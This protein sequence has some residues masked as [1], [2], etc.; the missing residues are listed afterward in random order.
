VSPL[1]GCRTNSELCRV[2]RVGTRTCPP[3]ARRTAQALLAQRLRRLGVD[4]LVPLWRHAASKSEATRSAGNGPGLLM[5]RCSKSTGSS[6]DSLAP[7]EWAKNTGCSPALMGCCF[8]VVIGDW[9]TRGARGL[10][11]PSSRPPRSW[12]AVP[13]QTALGAG[14]ARW[15][16]GG[17]SRDAAWTLPPPMASRKLVQRFELM[18][19]VAN[20]RT[21]APSW[22][23]GRVRMSSSCPMGARSRGDLQTQ[24]DWPWRD[25]PQV[26]GVRYARLRA[27]SS[28]YGAV[29]LIVVSEA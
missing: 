6:W 24:S 8:V 4:V 5:I 11:H 20:G 12:G 10:C 15:T 29:T 9:Q 3:S 2:A 21:R 7:V 17:L 26:P 25:S 14:H 22:W 23:K 1:F 27:T 19:H 28:T 13:R 16:P 18:R